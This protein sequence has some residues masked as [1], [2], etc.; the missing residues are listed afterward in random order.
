MLGEEDEGLRSGRTGFGL[1][2]ITL[3]FRRAPNPAHGGHRNQRTKSAPSEE[4]RAGFLNI[5]RA[6][7]GELGGRHAL[8]A[9]KAN[10]AKGEAPENKYEQEDD[11]R[12]LRL[13]RV[14]V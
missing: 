9:R 7:G 12:G 5:A 2:R 6:G 1:R 14:H 11:P 8:C 13:R 3:V 10:N 4:A